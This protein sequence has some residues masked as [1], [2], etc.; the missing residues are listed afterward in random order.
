MNEH[1]LDPSVPAQQL[2]VVLPE[3]EQIAQGNIIPPYRQFLNCIDRAYVQSVPLSI[4]DVGAGCGHYGVALRK[5]GHPLAEGYVAVDCSEAF[6]DLARSQWPWMRFDV[7]DSSRLPYGDLA[8]DI[9]LHSACL[10][11]SEDP[12][13]DIREAARVSADWVILHRTP[14]A[15]VTHLRIAEAYGGTLQEQRFSEPDLFEMF[16]A[17]GLVLVQEETIFDTGDGH[18]HKTYLLRKNQQK[19]PFG[20]RDLG[21]K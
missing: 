17:A 4:L 16:E 6:R 9:V 21:F 14:V 19:T 12:L 10:M 1:W 8:F 3:L 15:P 18:C 2:A 13:R 5:I 7:S 11:Y 20:S